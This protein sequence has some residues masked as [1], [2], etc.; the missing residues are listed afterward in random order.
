MPKANIRLD[1][2]YKGTDFAGWQYQP[3]EITI[4]GEIEKTLEKITAQKVTLYGAGRTD[5]GVH[6]LGQV[7]NFHIDHYLPAE[8]Y[9]E[10]LNFYLP[11]T[12]RITKSV[13]V[14]EA[15]HARKSGLWRHYRYII[16]RQNTALFFDY[17]WEYPFPLNVEILNGLAECIPGRHDFSAFCTVASQKEDNNCEVYESSWSEE[18]SLLIYDIRGNRFLHSMV[19]SLVGMMT[20]AGRGERELALTEFGEIMASKDHTRIGKVAPARGLYLVEVG[21]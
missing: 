14:A 16:D 2:Q 21:Y 9:R 3:D 8:K 15:F 13:A 17:R 18:S 19:R 7:A 1:I 11:R 6:A 20:E 5:A 10:A 12:I 4:Q